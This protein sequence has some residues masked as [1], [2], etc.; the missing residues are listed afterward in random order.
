MGV[1]FK[2]YPQNIQQVY[3]SELRRLKVNKEEPVFFFSLKMYKRRLTLE[4]EIR[5]KDPL[6]QHLQQ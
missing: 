3:H 1:A 4:R 6:L 5:D 2:T